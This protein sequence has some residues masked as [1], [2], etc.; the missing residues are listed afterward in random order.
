M[1]LSG[2]P[3]SKP[4][5][6]TQAKA[7]GNTASAG[8]ATGGAGAPRPAVG[9]AAWSSRRERQDGGSSRKQTDSPCH[10][11]MTHL[12]GRPGEAKAEAPADTGAPALTAA[13]LTGATKRKGTALGAPDGRRD[14]RSAGH[15]TGRAVWHLLCRGPPL[16]ASGR[17]K[18]PVAKG[19][20]PSGS[21]QPRYQKQSHSWDR[22]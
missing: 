17:A 20:I 18:K 11:A 6:H 19:Q 1:H 5:R 8:R 21:T 9:R 7:D 14:T 4:Q 13:L 10:P 16:K 15:P 2:W 22:Q 12:G 3:L